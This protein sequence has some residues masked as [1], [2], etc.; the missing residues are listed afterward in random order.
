MSTAIGLGFV[1]L[2]SASLAGQTVSDL[3]P[4][5]RIRVNAPS[6]YDRP[7]IGALEG[8]D[9]AG[10]RMRLEAG[11]NLNVPRDVVDGIDVSGGLRSHRLKGAAVGGLVGFTGGLIAAA[12]GREDDPFMP[13]F[14][15]TVEVIGVVVMTA[16]GAG[17]GALVGALIRTERWEEVY[18]ARLQFQKP[19]AR[20]L[21]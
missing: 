19:V 11:G 6:M 17:V 1:L 5:L 2:A 16:A 12:H 14:D 7:A 20:V 8:I 9:A 18:P 13:G 4:G 3:E 21:F 15:R 10:L